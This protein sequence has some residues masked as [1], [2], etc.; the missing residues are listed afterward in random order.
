MG[1][2]DRVGVQ[3]PEIHPI[4]NPRLRPSEEQQRQRRIRNRHGTSVLLLDSNA[5]VV[6]VVVVVVVCIFLVPKYTL[7]GPKFGPKMG[8]NGPKVQATQP[9]STH[10]HSTHLSFRSIWMKDHSVPP[11]DQSQPTPIR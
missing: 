2:I 4:A 8:K 6:V 9:N 3:Q 5:R 10:R 7:D 11:T 1:E